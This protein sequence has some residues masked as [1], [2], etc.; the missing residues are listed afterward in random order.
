MSSLAFPTAN[1]HSA[2][3]IAR[4]RAVTE[5]S[6]CDTYRGERVRYVSPASGFH[7]SLHL[8][9]RFFFTHPPTSPLIGSTA[10]GVWS[11]RRGASRVQFSFLFGL[12]VF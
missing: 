2:A 4:A 5:E 10:T 8:S 12:G 9:G 6:E 3:A 7:L 11:P 1:E